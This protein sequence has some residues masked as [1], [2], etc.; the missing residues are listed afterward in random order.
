MSVRKN[1][2]SLT[3]AERAAFI[4]AVKAVKANGIYDIFVE[5]HRT[6]MLDRT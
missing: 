6:A 4:A 5:Q 2:A 1:Q 3:V